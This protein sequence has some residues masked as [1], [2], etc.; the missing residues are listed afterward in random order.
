VVRDF[1]RIPPPFQADPLE[2]EQIFTNLFINAI[3]EMPSRGILS[4]QLDHDDKRM[5]IRVSDTGK[6]IPAANLANIFDP[7]F[8]TK[9]CGIGMGLAVVLRIVKTYFGRIEVEKSDEK[10]TTF[11]I[12]IPFGHG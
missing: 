7:F 1:R 11:L 10:G 2:I 3:H 9:S 12:T 6:G 5:M 4:I 8:T